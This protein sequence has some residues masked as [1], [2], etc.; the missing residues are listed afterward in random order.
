MK[1]DIIRNT[2]KVTEKFMKNLTEGFEQMAEAL[3]TFKPSPALKPAADPKVKPPAVAKP[4]AV[5]PTKGIL[6][7]MN[8][9]SRFPNDST[10]LFF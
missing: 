5:T 10:W 7:K 9:F 3:K 6:S 8:E 4:S 2:N 1:G